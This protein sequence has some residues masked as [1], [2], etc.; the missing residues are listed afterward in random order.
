MDIE[1]KV[2]VVTSV[3]VQASGSDQEDAEDERRGSG[4]GELKKNGD[5]VDRS[6]KTSEVA[7]SEAKTAIT[8]TMVRENTVG[9]IAP[10]DTESD[11]KVSSYIVNVFPFL[12]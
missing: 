1:G 3:K 6:R 10:S 9:D 12:T 7:I 2:E 5:E 11:G 8:I 4:E